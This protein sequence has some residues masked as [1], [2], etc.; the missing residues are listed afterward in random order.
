[1]RKNTMLRKVAGR[2]AYFSMLHIFFCAINCE[3][4]AIDL[5]VQFTVNLNIY[6]PRSWLAY[7]FQSQC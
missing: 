2:S 4:T 3:S 7:Y 1:M 5:L 6:F